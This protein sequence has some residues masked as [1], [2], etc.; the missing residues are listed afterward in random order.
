MA[1]TIRIFLKY[2]GI[3]GSG[4]EDTAHLRDKHLKIILTNMTNTFYVLVQ[5]TNTFYV[6]CCNI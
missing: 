3:F 6:L 5:M 1:Q 2:F 4:K